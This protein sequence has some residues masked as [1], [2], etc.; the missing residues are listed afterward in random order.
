MFYWAVWIATDDSMSWQVQHFVWFCTSK[1]GG[2][3]GGNDELDNRDEACLNIA[4]KTWAHT[5]S[6]VKYPVPIESFCAFAQ[7]WLVRGHKG[8]AK[9]CDIIRIWQC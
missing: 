5:S 2:M 1:S 3:L 6:N 4:D 9:S 7:V 8:N